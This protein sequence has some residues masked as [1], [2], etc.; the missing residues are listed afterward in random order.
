MFEHIL[1]SNYEKNKQ[2]FIFFFQKALTSFDSLYSFK[3]RWGRFKHI[4]MML[5]RD[6]KL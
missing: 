2:M 4:Q 5:Y 6:W 3:F 1:F